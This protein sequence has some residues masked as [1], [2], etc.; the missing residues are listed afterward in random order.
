MTLWAK[1]GNN[2]Y[3]KEDSIDFEV[4]MLKNIDPCGADSGNSLTPSVI[5]DQTYTITDEAFTLQIPAF[6]YPAESCV[7]NYTTVVP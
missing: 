2:E 3:T 5:E 4:K 7:I 1:Y 6:T